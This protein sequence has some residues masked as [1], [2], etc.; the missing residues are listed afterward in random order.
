MASVVSAAVVSGELIIGLDDGSIIRAGYVQGPQ[1]LSGPQGPM[2]ATGSR[3]TDG[4]TIHTVKG[5]PPADLGKDGDYAINNR[6]WFIFGPREGGRWGA[7]KGMLPKQQKPIEAGKGGTTATGGGGGGG[8]GGSTGP[9]Y[10]NT[11]QL[12]APTRTLLASTTGYRVLP[13]AGPGKQNQQDA[14]RWAFGEVF[15]HIDQA[16]PVHTGELPPPTMPGFIDVYDGRLWFKTLN[17]ENRLY[18]YDDGE[19]LPCTEIPP[20]IFSEGPPDPADSKEGYLY[21]DTSEDDGTLYVFYSG[22]WVPAAPPVST[23]GLENNVSLL[24]EAV[25]GLQAT[26]SSHTLQIADAQSTQYGLAQL[27]GQTADDVQGLQESQ[28]AQDARLDALEGSTAPDL[29]GYVEKAG[30]AMTGTLQ[31]NGALDNKIDPLL[32]RADGYYIS[33]GVSKNG[34]V[35]AGASIS[36]P[37][38]A[39]ENWHVVT[40]G[41]LDTQI[42]TAAQIAEASLGRRFK[43]GTWDDVVN[44]GGEPGW[45]DTG[46]GS[47]AASNWIAMSLVD[48]DGLKVHQE[49]EVTGDFDYG[50]ELPFTMYAYINDEWEV[51]AG[52]KA[53]SQTDCK[54]NRFQLSEVTWGKFYPSTS[55]RNQ[56][57]RLKVGGL[58]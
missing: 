16:I 41:Y 31:I 44:S 37:F 8:S 40:K 3:G 42:P 25:Q 24:N 34:D 10:T 46:Q 5:P 9:I 53:R 18:I 35:F 4:N 17:D 56:I 49:C 29:S 54:D 21:F 38:L 28:A 7:G 50:I 22:Q 43:L 33:F 39:T 30:D 12:T 48:L 15:D 58:W 36:S 2:G 11:V 57:V 20:V 47:S 27:A 51:V 32:C 45:L 52:G 6:D 55:N 14:N 1:G 19:W 23:E 26:A 13:P